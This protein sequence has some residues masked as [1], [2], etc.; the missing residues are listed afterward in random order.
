M[1]CLT[2]ASVNIFS[3]YSTNAFLV[4]K[5]TLAE[6]MPGV[7]VSRFSLFKAQLAQV[8][9]VIVSFNFVIL[10]KLLKNE[11]FEKYSLFEQAFVFSKI[12]L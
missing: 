5:L 3:S 7:F 9:P 1:T 4:A 12:F 8:I 2:A 10:F 6:I 11:L